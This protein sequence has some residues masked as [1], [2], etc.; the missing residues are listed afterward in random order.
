MISTLAQTS[1]Q[2]PRLRCESTVLWYLHIYKM[3]WNFKDELE[4]NS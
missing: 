2:D 3:S 1:K 4:F